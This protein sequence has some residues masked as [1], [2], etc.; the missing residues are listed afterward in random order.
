MRPMPSVK[1]ITDMGIQYCCAD[2]KKPTAKWRLRRGEAPLC[3]FKA[4][5]W[6]D[7]KPFCKMHAGEELIRRMCD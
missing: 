6:I 5:Y 3:N 1:K 2:V 4:N 7:E